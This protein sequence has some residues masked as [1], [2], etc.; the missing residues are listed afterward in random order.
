[1]SSYTHICPNG[2]IGHFG[3][4]GHLGIAQMAGRVRDP[5][6]VYAYNAQTLWPAWPNGSIAQMAILA[7]WVILA[8]WAILAI[9]VIL[10]IWAYEP[11]CPRA[12]YVALV[13]AYDA[14]THLARMARC[15]HLGH[16]CQM[17]HIGHLGH[18]GH[19]GL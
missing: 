15:V 1:M 8:K 6:L 10:A 17:G 13:Y 16:I 9:W 12:T 2:H 7:I 19:M 3:H 5:S 4:I 14:Q 18:I 11:I